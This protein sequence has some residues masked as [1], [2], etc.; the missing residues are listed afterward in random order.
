[1]LGI[2]PDGAE[3]IWLTVQVAVV[4]VIASLPIG[5]ALALLLARVEFPG[6]MLVDGLVHLPLVLPP[7]VTGYLLLE[8]FLPHGP[9]GAPLREWFGLSVLFHWT[10]AA[11]AAA[12]MGLPLMVRT[13]RLSIEALDP[14]IEHA[15]RSLGGGRWH[16]FR[17]IT[18]PMV[19]PGI[20][21]GT[22]LAF[23]R[24]LGEFGATI[25]FVS[26]IPGETRTLPIAIYSLLQ[27]PGTEAEVMRLSIVSIILSLGALVLAEWLVKR[28][29]A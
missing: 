13:I 21:A 8:A 25:T 6:K 20:A 15:A 7:V 14:R 3:A 19:T 12:V 16:V 29:A 24:S 27:M 4:G 18:L 2:G 10:G 26:N 11:I 5:I 28:R 17:T 22:A 9:I 1:M 23:A